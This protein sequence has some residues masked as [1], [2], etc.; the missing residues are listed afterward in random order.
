MGCRVM[1]YDK[2]VGLTVQ[3]SKQPPA[4]CPLLT[5]TR[6]RSRGS[7]HT[8][9]HDVL[10]RAPYLAQHMTALH[11]WLKDIIICFTNT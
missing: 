1:S 5:G 4:A 7:L 10:A 9:S 8:P 6:S 2:M 3:D 11:L